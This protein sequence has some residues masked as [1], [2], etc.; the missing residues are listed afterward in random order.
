[1]KFPEAS[2]RFRT[3]RAPCVRCA[4]TPHWNPKHEVLRVHFD[5]SVIVAVRAQEGYPFDIP[6]QMLFPQGWMV[7]RNVFI[8][9]LCSCVLS[10]ALELGVCYY[11]E[12]WP[13]TQWEPAARRMAA[14]GIRYVRI[15]EFA[16][17]LMQPSPKE[18]DFGWLDR[19]IRALHAH[20]L[21]VVLGTPTATPPKWLVDRHPA[22]LPVGADGQVCVCA[23]DIAS[24]S[25]CL[26][27]CL[28]HSMSQPLMEILFAM[29]LGWF[30]EID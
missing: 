18:F 3:A 1:M 26:V 22:I 21:K 12:H 6:F 28:G 10:G 27:L 24:P 13:E 20:G 5:S 7:S 2:K 8:I 19:A 30:W 15:A 25:R 23:L 29:H 4:T 14:M 17:H 9:L 11:P 16:W